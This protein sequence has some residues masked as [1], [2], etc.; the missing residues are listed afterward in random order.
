MAERRPNILLLFTDQQRYDTIAALGNAV[1]RTPALDRLCREGVAFERCYTP[2]PVCV[3]GRASMVTGLPP[4]R[5]GCFDNGYPVD[6]GLPSFMEKLAE[7]GYQ[8]HG[9]GKM[10]FTPEAR[11][12]WGFASRD[13][14]EEMGRADDFRKFIDAHGYAHVDDRH[15]V[16]SEMYYI[17]QVS[18][19]PAELHETHWVAD[20]SIDFLERRDRGRP[21]FLWSSFVKPHPPFE[22]PTPWNKL[23]RAAEMAA[24]FRPEGFEKLQSFWNHVQNR[25]KYRGHGY[26]EMLMRTIRA[27]YYACI[28]FIDHNVGRILATLGDELDNTLVLFSSDHGELLGDYGCVGKRSMLDAA[29]RVPMLVRFP[30]RARAG[31]RC[32]R[33]VSLLDVWPTVLAAA[34]TVAGAGAEEAR[35]CDEGADLAAVA[36]GGVA[37]E[38]VYSQY[39]CG[40][41]GLYMATTRDEKYIYSAA[42]EREWFFDLKRDPRETRDLAANPQCRG[43]VEAMRARL[44]ERFKRDGYEEAIEDHG[45]R[46]Y[47][48]RRVEPG[49]DRGL[50]FQDNAVTQQ[51]ID[52]LEGYARPIGADADPLRDL[53]EGDS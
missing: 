26:D 18:Q 13:V 16:R 7:R 46:R 45:W 39:Q 14:S 3:P 53:L 10:H 25:Y 11:R 19:L 43:R 27:A 12:M 52:G 42:D 40:G 1:I 24:P 20:R 49:T 8:T 22:N 48:K 6:P 35:V 33:P 21:F 50:L 15:G 38:A 17:P 41:L 31:Q 2:S 37:R 32:E 4:H 28:S 36:D 9:V 23:Y 5:N 30:G 34:G 29:V 51:R 47:G 44:I